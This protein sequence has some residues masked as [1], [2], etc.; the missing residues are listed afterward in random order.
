MR[1]RPGREYSAEYGSWL[2][3]ICCIADALTFSALTSMPLTTIVTP[4]LPSEPA[5][6]NRD[7]VATKSLSKTGRLSSM[8]WSMVIAST[9]LPAAVPTSP[10]PVPTVTESFRLARPS[11]IVSSA[12]LRAPTRT[13]TVPDLKAGNDARTL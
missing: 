3:R 13:C 11:T 8:F 4:P 9:L 12:G 6:R 5:S 10:L 1:P 2:I 7:I